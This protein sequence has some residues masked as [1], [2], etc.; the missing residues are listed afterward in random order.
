M[1]RIDLDRLL[2]QLLCLYA[3]LVPFELVLEIFF[4]IDTIFKPYRVVCLVLI[5]LY[6]LRAIK[7]GGFSLSK[8]FREDSFLYLVFIYGIL[9]SFYNMIVVEF[10]LGKFYNKLFQ[11]AL[12]LAVFAIV[13]GLPM[14]REQLRK[15]QRYLL[16]G[17]VING[18]YV[19]ANR[20]T[21]ITLNRQSGFFD[22][23]NYLSLGLIY[24]LGYLAINLKSVK[25]SDKVLYLILIPI[26][27][28]AFLVAGSRTG[29]LVMMVVLL[30]M[31]SFQSLRS[32]L[33]GLVV[34]AVL[35]PVYLLVSDTN[36][37]LRPTT[38]L[39]DRF[40]DLDIGDDPR[41]PIWEG[42]IRASMKTNFVGLGLGQFEARFP[43]FYR[44]ENN[45]VIYEMLA[46]GYYLSP[47]SDYLAVLVSFG[48]VGLV[49]FLLFFF[50][51]IRKILSLFWRSTGDSLLRM[52]LI[53]IIALVIFGI[54]AENFVSGLYW[55]ILT[56]STKCAFEI[57]EA[58]EFGNT[59]VV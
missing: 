9:I 2:F 51:S 38:V 4:G 39:E 31:L 32:I 55:L 23:P 49:F 11:N 18:I 10:H 54:A 48:I 47:H 15:I 30:L 17:L 8:D 1:I 5:G 41:F 33:I 6:S 44:E 19:L 27:L 52:Q 24:A 29:A 26:C 16:W 42:V 20:Y 45:I 34:L 12:Y 37:S 3:F 59:K 22:N 21:G 46:Y 36:L 58:Q 13:K 40:Q 35:S 53:G 25:F 7:Q 14:T 57:D 56:L 43:E 28:L 50:F